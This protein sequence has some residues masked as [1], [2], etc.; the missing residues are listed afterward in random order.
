[1]QHHQG[2]HAQ[3]MPNF[4]VFFAGFGSVLAFDTSSEAMAS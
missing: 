4:V 1:M 2:A 3:E